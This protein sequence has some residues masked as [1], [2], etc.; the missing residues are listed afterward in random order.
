MA[1]S[2]AKELIKQGEQL[3]SKRAPL[4]SLWQDIADN[5]YPERADFTVCRNIGDEFG[6][7]LT[8]SYPLLARRELGSLISSMMRPSN[9]EWFEVS[10]A[11]DD[12]LDNAGREWLQWA[13]G[14][15]R[16]AMYDQVTQFLR[17]TKEA[18]NDYAT[19]GQAVLS[20][21][22]NRNRDALLYRSYHLRD[23]VWCENSEGMADN[24]HRKWKPSIRD[25]IAQFGVEQNGHI[26]GVHSTVKSKG[27]QDA[28]HQVECRHV[29]LPSD[30]YD[31]GSGPNGKRWKTPYVSVFVD[32][33]NE[34]ILEEVGVN[35]NEYTIPRWQT[36]SGSQYAYSPCT[37]AALPD[38]R[39][40]QA[41]TLVLLEAGEKAVNPPMIA[42][43]D[44][45]RSDISIYA[46][47]VT[48]VDRDYDERLGEAL[49]P[50]IQDTSGIPLGFEM[51]SDIKAQIAEAFYLNKINLPPPQKDMTAFEVGQRVQ[52]Y[53]RG[54]MPLFEPMEMDY[55]ANLCMN[56]FE[57]LQGAGAFGSV[58]DMPESLRGQDVRF[59]FTSP[60]YE[61]AEKQKGRTFLETKAMLAEAA[62]IDPGSA[63]MFDVREALR[64]TL[65]AIGTPAKWLLSETEMAD[66]EAQIQQKQQ[67]QEMLAGLQ[68]G[69]QVAEQAGKAAQALQV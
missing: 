50:M 62:A 14:L 33:E 45:I 23:V 11:R 55:N 12:K 5:F 43:Q 27:E 44:I 51:R 17:A 53:I 16:R 63:A 39:L 25:L 67:M 4:L 54:A 56:T 52:E 60:L 8:T 29:I 58:F 6:M 48:W 41:M 1:D 35:Y 9:E 57:V 69:G 26:H 46:G 31:T 3:F 7:G 19:F 37:V 49:R 13:T 36:V 22:L 18:D 68:A 65:E 32:L 21:R 15:Q 59:K 42:T 47:G 30:L 20:T 64:D 66:A 34:H 10:V 2:R 40:I 24:V 61:A 38:A 28:Y